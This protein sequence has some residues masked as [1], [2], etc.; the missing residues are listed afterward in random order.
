MPPDYVKG[1]P[2]EGNRGS[3]LNADS[4]TN[5]ST[6]IT[7]G[8]RVS[9]SLAGL[10]G[11]LAGKVTIDPAS[12][13]YRATGLGHDPD[14]Y[15]RYSGEGAHRRVWRELVGEIPAGL[16]LDH[17]AARGCTW[18]DCVLVAHLEP[19][20]PRVNVLRGRSF[21]AINAAK[22]VCDNGHEYDMW[23]TYWRPNGHRD[24]RACIR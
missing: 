3:D 2:P 9:A 11:W 20:P 17:V 21:S 22:D 23:N 24:C 6:S 8:A 5:A 13:C 10:P 15:A 7:A 16:V 1:R 14:G 19:V 12:G 4:V 18:R